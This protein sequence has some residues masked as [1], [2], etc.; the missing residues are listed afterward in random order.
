MA[1]EV[2]ADLDPKVDRQLWKMFSIG[3][4]MASKEKKSSRKA[5]KA[6][7]AEYLERLSRPPA[8]A[9]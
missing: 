5:K 6:A 8:D 9:P 3:W 2:Q 4:D 1:D 7:W